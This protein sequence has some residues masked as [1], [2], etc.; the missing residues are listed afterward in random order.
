M[1]SNY[2]VNQR[3]IEES[4]GMNDKYRF[5]WMSVEREIK[6]QCKLI[7]LSQ[8]RSLPFTVQS[9]RKEEKEKMGEWEKRAGI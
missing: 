7:H 8:K 1:I 6:S 4:M 9:V 3:L 5:Q 2:C